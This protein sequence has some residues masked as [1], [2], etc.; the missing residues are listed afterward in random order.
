MVLKI[1][2]FF[3]FIFSF[4]CD[5]QSNPYMPSLSNSYQNNIFI[6]GNARD[7]I[8]LK[9]V[10]AENFSSNS[11]GFETSIM[12]PCGNETD[13]SDCHNR[14]WCFWQSLIDSYVFDLIQV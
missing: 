12:T 9:N 4:S 3:M 14:F 7:F 5:K 6:N 10:N 8:I 13:V 2:I 1:I 11:F